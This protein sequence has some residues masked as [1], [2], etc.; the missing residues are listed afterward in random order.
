MHSK[1]NV[2]LIVRSMPILAVPGWFE[3][4]IVPNEAMVVKELKSTA[5]GVVVDN[6]LSSPSTS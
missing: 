4:E 3:S 6:R 5:L 1:V 2:T